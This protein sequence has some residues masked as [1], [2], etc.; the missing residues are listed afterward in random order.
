M[1]FLE[2]FGCGGCFGVHKDRVWKLRAFE[3]KTGHI[4]VMQ[5]YR[6][7]KFI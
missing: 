3:K 6:E 2:D 7:L 5:R 1:N 4:V